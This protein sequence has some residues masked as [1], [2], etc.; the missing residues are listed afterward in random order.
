MTNPQE[1]MISFTLPLKVKPVPP[2]RIRAGRLPRITR[3][4]ALALRFEDLLNSRTVRDYADLARL[5][6]VSRA[7][8]T[9][10]MN[11][12]NLAP[13]IQEALLF[14]DPVTAW[15]DPINER[16]FRAVIDEPCWEKQRKVFAALLPRRAE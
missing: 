15:R 5:G 10:I 2:P 7:R 8:I 14:L 16:T 1:R 11:L 13:D 12:L 3:L 9:Q 4:M 6:E